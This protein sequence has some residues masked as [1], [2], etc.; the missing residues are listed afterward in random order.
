MLSIRVPWFEPFILVA[1]LPG[2]VLQKV[3]FQS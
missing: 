1:R 2:S 3:P